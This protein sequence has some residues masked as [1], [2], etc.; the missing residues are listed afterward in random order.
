MKKLK[1][2]GIELSEIKYLLLTHYHDDHAGFGAQLIKETEARLIAHKNAVPLLE[3][4]ISINPFVDKKGRN[5]NFCVKMLNYFHS[6]FI[7]RTFTYPPIKI[8]NTD[9]VIE[10]DDD[11][12]LKEIDIEGKILHT[13]GHTSDSISVLL[14]DGSA[15]VGDAAVNFLNICHIKYRPIYAE[16]YE[17]VFKSWDKLIRYGAKIIYPA[18]G[19]PFNVEKLE[20]QLEK[21][22]KK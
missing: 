16:N 13:P 3:K 14:S 2:I 11:E 5:L 20:L 10:S 4:G 15:I 12:V 19:N 9:I 22:T 17:D 1:K 7:S 6:M 18:H 21:I 8:K